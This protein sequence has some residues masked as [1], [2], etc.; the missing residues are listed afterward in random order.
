[1]EQGRFHQTLNF[2]TQYGEQNWGTNYQLV[3][4]CQLFELQNTGNEPR[5]AQIDIQTFP[6]KSASSAEDL[7][8][9]DIAGA[10]VLEFRDELDW[11]LQRHPARKLDLKC[12]NSRL[13][14]CARSSGF[15]PGSPATGE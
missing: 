12:A 14:A 13:K 9:P 4:V 6:V 2:G 8:G 10:G 5:D 11:N 15:L 3:V 1:M 7:D